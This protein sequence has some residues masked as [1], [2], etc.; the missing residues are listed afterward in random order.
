M[1]GHRTDAEGHFLVLGSSPSLGSWCCPCLLVASTLLLK[2]RSLSSS[3]GG[4]A[5]EASSGAHSR[6]SFKGAKGPPQHPP[7][8]LA[9]MQEP[10]PWG[11]G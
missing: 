4:Q 11:Q 6:L 1:A 7:C 8:D 9:A 2:V 3:R 10:F 5:N